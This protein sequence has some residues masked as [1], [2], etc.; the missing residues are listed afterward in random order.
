MEQRRQRSAID[1]AT[2]AKICGYAQRFRVQRVA[3]VPRCEPGAEIRGYRVETAA[4]HDAR[5]V[6]EGLRVMPVDLLTDPGRLAGDIAVMS[7][8][9]HAG[10]N[11]FCAVETKGSRGA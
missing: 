1:A 5:A 8:V 10:I 6:G 11:E 2:D 3:Q 9:A 4:G 7:P